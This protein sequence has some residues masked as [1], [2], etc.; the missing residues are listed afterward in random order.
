M[1]S[2]SAEV[3]VVKPENSSELKFTEASSELKSGV[4][5][6]SWMLE[7][8]NVKLRGIIF[9]AH[10]LAEHSR[11]YDNFA[12]LLCSELDVVVVSHDHVGHGKSEGERV[13]VETFDVF[14]KDVFA[15]LDEI[16][17]SHP[18]LPVYIFGHSM[19]GTIATLAA[20]EKPDY[21]AAV[22]LSSP[23]ILIAPEIAPGRLKVFFG[24]MLNR[25]FPRM[26]IL[27][28]VD[29]IAISTDPK[30]VEEYRT[31]PLIWHSGVKLRIATA[32]GDAMDRIK[33][34]IP[35]IQWPFLVIH[36]DNDTLTYIGGSELL[37]KEAKSEDKEIKIYKGLKHELLNEVKE[38]AEKV[39][40]H[41]V[42]WLRKRII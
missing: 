7:P 23:G 33:N 22:V 34:W 11:R 4:K 14:V 29:P 30:T 27:P 15:H 17:K 9:I 32:F 8:Q 40:S 13:M 31:D 24:R 39:K 19:G 1:E 41:V 26:Q 37:E 6:Y 10:G 5:I 28:P 42:E 21:F 12:R 20:C 18:D 36:G 25:F 16:K 35:S 38:E 2:S 3:N